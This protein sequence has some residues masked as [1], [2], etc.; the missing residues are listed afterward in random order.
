MRTLEPPDWSY[1]GAAWGVVVLGLGFL[2]MSDYGNLG[3]LLVTL[4]LVLMVY[5]LRPSFRSLFGKR[6]AIEIKPAGSVTIEHQAPGF[7]HG[8][9]KGCHT[10]R[11]EVRV[12]QRA[13]KV[14]FVCRNSLYEALVWVHESSFEE[15]PEPK[16]TRHEHWL[17]LTFPDENVLFGAMLQV[18]LFSLVPVEVLTIEVSNP[19][20]DPPLPTASE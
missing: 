10:L 3:R 15:V 8:L 17:E 6:R 2:F 16:T 1:F 7:D 4:G 19:P 12:K 9:G 5:S 18:L 13:R 20:K 11:L 14:L